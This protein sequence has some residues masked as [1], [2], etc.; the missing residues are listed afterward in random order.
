M[1]VERRINASTGAVELWWCEWGKGDMAGAKKIYVNKIADEA[2]AFGVRRSARLAHRGVCD[3][4]G[5]WQDARE[6]RGLLSDDSGQ[7]PR[8]AWGQRHSAL[9][10]RDCRKVSPWRPALVVPSTISG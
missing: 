10:L 1:F 2:D 8:Q 9:R 6:H 7:L 4:L 3:L 5:L